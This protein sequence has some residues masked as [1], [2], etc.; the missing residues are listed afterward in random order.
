MANVADRLAR[1]LTFGGTDLDDA[2]STLLEFEPTI[3]VRPLLRARSAPGEVWAVDGGQALVADARCLQVIA[4]RAA[5]VRFV[6]GHCAVED[7][8]ELRVTLL[9]QEDDRCAAV[10]TLSLDGLPDDSAV[11]VNLWRDRWEWAAVEAAIDDAEAHC[12]AIVLVDGDLQPDWRI[13][14]AYVTALLARASSKGVTVAGITKHTALS[15]GGAPL[16]AQLEREAEARFGRDAC[17]WAPIGRTR[18]DGGAVQVVAARFDPAARFSFRV[19]IAVGADAAETLA[20]IATLC[21]DAGFPGYPY[22][23]TVAD[24]LAAI[25]GWQRADLRFDLDDLLSRAGIGDDVRERAFADR[26]RMMER[27]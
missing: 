27:A 2:G 22:P 14:R 23:L 9:G 24:R 15:R 11:D 5:R 26:H 25:P 12:G 13:P 17:W 8:G 10:A 1:L 6:D 21:D 19:D 16:L 18:A 3:D 7:E 20:S 4:A